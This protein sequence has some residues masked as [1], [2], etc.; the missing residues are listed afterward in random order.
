M[1]DINISIYKK[2]NM[3]YKKY[4]QTLA[5]GKGSRGCTPISTLKVVWALMPE[6]SK[7]ISF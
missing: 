3:E 4:K 6:Q 1:F 7:V 2:V 5:H